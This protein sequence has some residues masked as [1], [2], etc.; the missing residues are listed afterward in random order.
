MLNT[1]NEP[2]MLTVPLTLEA[3][4]IAQQFHQQH[5][6]QKAKQ[7]YLNTL[8]VYA[9]KTSLKCLGIPTNWQASDSWNP[10]MQTLENTADLLIKDI[11]KLECR[12]VL[13]NAASC[14]IPAEVWSERIGYVAVELNQALTEAKLLGFLPSVNTEEVLL[15]QL[16]SLEH[17]LEHINPSRQPIQLNQWLQNIFDVGWQTVDTLFDSSPT[18]LAFNFRNYTQIA[19][20]LSEPSDLKITRGK[21]L[22]LGRRYD[23]EQVILVM[24]LI[25]T[26]SSELDISVEIYPTNGQSYLPKNLRLM[27]LDDTGE[28]VMQAE[29]RS[30]KQIQLQFSGEAGECFKVRVALADISITETFI[31]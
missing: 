16:K 29:A 8:A 18:E 9:V 10:I 3:H 27:I 28:T 26:R 20:H 22:T 31:I 19:T 30:T 1:T 2:L 6:P 17:L 12:P 21:R 24:N 15:T 4:Q 25:P 7:V 5:C 23:D 14:H 13:P 11:G